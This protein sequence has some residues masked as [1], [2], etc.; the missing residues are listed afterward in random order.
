M[1]AYCKKKLEKVYLEYTKNETNLRI[2]TFKDIDWY[3]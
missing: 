1:P 3:Y 2:C